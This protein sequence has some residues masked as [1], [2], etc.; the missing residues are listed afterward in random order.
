MKSINY[1]NI[2]KL[3]SNYRYKGIASQ[4]RTSLLRICDSIA[5]PRSNID[6]SQYYDY[7]SSQYGLDRCEA[8]IVALMY[9]GIIENT[10]TPTDIAMLLFGV[11]F[12]NDVI[13]ALEG[14]E[15]NALICA[16]YDCE[17]RCIQRR[18]DEA[19]ILSIDEDL[20][21][22]EAQNQIIEKMYALAGDAVYPQ[23]EETC[24]KAAIKQLAKLPSNVDIWNLP[25][26]LEPTPS[27][28]Y[29]EVCSLD[30]TIT[31]YPDAPFSMA[32]SEFTD[33]L[34]L[35]EKALLLKL[36]RLFERQ[37]TKPI[38]QESII[39]TDDD[40]V[41]KEDLSSLLER[42]LVVSVNVLDDKEKTT[43]SNY[44]RISPDV[45]TFFRG[46]E[47]IINKN[48]VSETGTY[49]SADEIEKKELFFSDSD[50]H[51]MEC[52]RRSALPDE[53]ERIIQALKRKRLRPCVSSLL[54]GPPGTG[55]TEMVRQ[56]ALATGRAIIRG[57]AEK[58]VAVYMGEGE[59]SFKNFFQN[60][61]YACAVSKRVPILF[62]DE[63]DGLLGKRISNADNSAAKEM[64]TIQ[65]VVLDELN[66][67]PG[68]FIV[69]TNLIEN[70]DQAMFRRFMIKAEFHLPDEAARTRIWLS[71]M[72]SLRPEDA[73]LLARRYTLSGGLIDNVIS[74]IVMEE[75]IFNREVTLTDIFSMCDSEQ[76]EKEVTR[77]RIGF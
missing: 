34:S 30:E 50:Q 35:S 64:N 73:E 54:Y 20:T 28:E 7:L 51:V 72:P 6:T 74:K 33:G 1:K 60:Y 39:E 53:Y 69:T 27:I 52:I 5:D 12:N 38:E 8:N 29:S 23:N 17:D 71:K 59:K 49:I 48:V 26:H 19:L 21:L 56:I 47:E 77:R 63:A 3:D 57:D 22:L 25:A 58:L 66:S 61:R 2:N 40:S 62:L 10:D 44:Y 36:M 41:L 42:G 15:E 11:C 43:S 32:L 16:D 14:L 70:L 55:K 13:Y 68:I 24:R 46:K 76:I 45:A 4:G 31:R 67:L 9:K 37:F 75:I 65:N 18:L